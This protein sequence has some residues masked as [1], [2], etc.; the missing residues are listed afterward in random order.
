LL[1]P[2]LLNGGAH[3]AGGVIDDDDVDTVGG[4]L[5]KAIGR[6]PLP[7]AAGDTQGVHL[8]AEEATGRRRQVSTILASRTP[9]PEEDT[10]D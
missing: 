2:Q 10:D 7:G 1:G 4:L 5:T 6:V 3:L 8:Q 9:A